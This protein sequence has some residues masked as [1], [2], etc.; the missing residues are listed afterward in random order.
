[1]EASTKKRMWRDLLLSILLDGIGMVTYA[2]PVLGETGDVVWAPFAAW[3]V[4]RMYEKSS[5]VVGSIVTLIEEALPG[6]DIVPSF[7]IMWF[8]TYVIRQ[9]KDLERGKKKKR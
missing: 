7:L 1:M 9:G 4:Y 5:G 6:T 3:L 8:Y 2:L